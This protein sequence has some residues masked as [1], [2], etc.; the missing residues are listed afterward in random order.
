M[1]SFTSSIQN[2]IGSVKNKIVS[3]Q[4]GID[5]KIFSH[6]PCSQRSTSE[7]HKLICRENKTLIRFFL[8]EQFELWSPISNWNKICPSSQ[9]QWIFFYTPFQK[10]RRTPDRITSKA[11]PAKSNRGLEVSQLGRLIGSAAE[12]SNSSSGN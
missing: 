9:V 1:T 8:W 5:R 12:T 2:K 4:I 7:K 10:T 6:F 11:P 3:F